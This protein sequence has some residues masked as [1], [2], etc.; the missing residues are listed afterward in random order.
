[1]PPQD[2]TK[3]TDRDRLNRVILGIFDQDER[4]RSVAI[5]QDQY[6]LAGGMRP[7]ARS[8][9]PEEEA[10]EIDL[11]L[12]KV[13]EIARSWQRWFGTLVAF[14]IKYERVTLAF[15]P[16]GAG[17]FLVISSEPDFD[18]A[19]LSGFMSQRGYRALKED[20]P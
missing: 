3:K 20:I 9:D 11:Q 1:M 17:R 16:L 10:R 13:G 5:Y 6:Q 8:H 14:T 19:S 4:I 18:T 2:S 15:H 12:A 7:G